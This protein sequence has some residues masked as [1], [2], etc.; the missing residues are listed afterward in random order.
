MYQRVFKFLSAN[1]CFYDLQFGFRDHHS[2]S[3]SLI[4][5]TEKIRKALDNNNFACG[6]FIDLKKAFD[7]V[8]HN[9]LLSKL[10]HYG[11]RGVANNWFS[12]YLS[13]RQQHVSIEGFNSSKLSVNIG[14]PQGSVLGPLL[15]LIYLNDLHKSII[16]S[17]VHHFADDTNLLLVDKSPKTISKKLNADLRKLCNWLK[18]NKI[19]LNVAKTELIIFRHPNKKLLYDLV[20]K[21]DGKRLQPV[22]SIKYLGLQIDETLSFQK[23][24]TS[25][26]RKLSRSNSM[27]AKI[28]HFVPPDTLKSIYHSIFASH[29]S[30]GCIVWGQKGNPN[31]HKIYSLQNSALRLISFSDFRARTNLIYQNLNILSLSKLVFLLNC[32]L[33][34]SQLTNNIPIGLR[35]TFVPTNRVHNHATRHASQSIVTPVTRTTKY[36][37]YS[38]TY[39]CAS[40]WN[41]LVAAHSHANLSTL[42]IPSLKKYIKKYLFSLP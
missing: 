29:M 6:I 39:Q 32:L 16:H 33:V 1:G 35:N 3:H 20:I 38:I 30:Y 28:R 24:L 27:L 5:L 19:A 2:T 25:L 42:S 21:L 8:D 31:C 26:S 9:I 22:H 4:S 40:S 41:K 10:E 12:S 11:I 17:S 37:L 34:H 36:G 14:V 13:N 7:T 18:A 15:F 23:H